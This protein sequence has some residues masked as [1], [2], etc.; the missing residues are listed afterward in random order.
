MSRKEQ[1]SAIKDAAMLR[2]MMLVANRHSWKKTWAHGCFR[3]PR[4]SNGICKLSA[5]TYADRE[6]DK[7]NKPRRFY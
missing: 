1:V 6:G 5:K 2:Q 4:I 7:L 3:Y